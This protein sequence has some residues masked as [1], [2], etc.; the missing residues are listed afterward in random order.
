MKDD[1]IDN[2]C[3]KCSFSSDNIQELVMHLKL[4]S[5]VKLLSCPL[6]SYSTTFIGSLKMHIL[7]AHTG[8]HP[9]CCPLCGYLCKKPN[10]L[11]I[12]MKSHVQDIADSKFSLIKDSKLAREHH[13][14]MTELTLV[15][16]ETSAK[17]GH[18]EKDCLDHIDAIHNANDQSKEETPDHSYLLKNAKL[19]KQNLS[20]LR[21]KI[22]KKKNFFIKK[23][24]SV[25]PCEKKD[26]IKQRKGIRMDKIS[27]KFCNKKVIRDVNKIYDHSLKCPNMEKSNK[28]AYM[29]CS[30][31]YS[32][33]YLG[34]LNTHVLTV[35]SRIEDKPHKCGLCEFR[36]AYSQSLVIHFRTHT[37]EKPFKCDLCDFKSTTSS[38]LK[39]HVKIHHERNTVRERKIHPLQPIPGFQLYSCK[40]CAFKAKKFGTLNRHLNS[41]HPQC[42]NFIRTDEN[43]S[44]VNEMLQIEMNTESDAESEHNQKR[45]DLFAEKSSF[46]QF[47]NLETRSPSKQSINEESLKNNLHSSHLKSTETNVSSQE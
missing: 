38:S 20:P 22:Q 19:I 16:K 10:G 30:C 1:K 24:K 26:I 44:I 37:G 21:L 23:S 42:S 31:D 32:S 15:E 34:L 46:M 9:L 45:R 27:C 14:E 28:K 35:H 47:L 36:T 40:Y 6:C 33:S 41:Q 11:S 3:Y 13:T 43:S 17:K 2:I 29:C 5:E 18:S 12:H 8:N 4:H 7:K 39:S 25:N